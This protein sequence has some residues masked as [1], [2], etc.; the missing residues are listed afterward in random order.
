MFEFGTKR[1]KNHNL[2]QSVVLDFLDKENN[3]K[4]EFEIQHFLFANYNLSQLFKHTF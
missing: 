1:T 3:F 2:I 4:V